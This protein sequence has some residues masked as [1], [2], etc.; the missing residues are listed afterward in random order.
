MK[1]IL[2]FIIL[3]VSVFS[4][5]SEA[6]FFDKL[7]K[8]A[9]KVLK[10]KDLSKTFSKDEAAK[11]IKEALAKGVSKGTD[12]VSKKDGYF[13]NTEI[14]IP[15]PK[16]AKTVEKTLRKVGMGKKVDKA[17]ETM[18]RAA[19]DAATKAKEVFL[20]VIKKMTL[21]DA[22]NIVKGEDDAATRYLEKNTTN[23]LTEKFRPIIEKSLQKVDGTKHWNS[24]MSAYNKIP[25]VDKINPDL[26]AYVTEKALYGLFVMIEKE[27]KDIRKDPVA[28]TTDLLKKVF[29][30]K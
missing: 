28:R 29:G 8:E 16:E 2:L 12:L 20:T 10:K 19:E 21:K 25:F 18:N 26:T 7:K 15:F 27:E 9:N 5:K 4:F 23:T 30:G 24:V 22:V 17:V 3:F 13:K 14:K 6:Q 11:A 1:T